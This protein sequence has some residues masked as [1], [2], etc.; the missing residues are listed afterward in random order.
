LPVA[1]TGRV[2]GFS[3][4]A[5]EYL[6]SAFA[7]QKKGETQRSE[8][9]ALGRWARY[10]GETPL[11][12]I[13]G[14]M[15]RAYVEARMGGTFKGKDGV[16]MGA[17][18][19]RTCNLDLTSLRQCLKAAEACGKLR[20]L[21]VI[22][23]LRTVPAVSKRLLTSGEFEA[24]L[25]AVERV[26][27]RNARIVGLYLRF[28]AFT[29]CREKEALRVSWGAVDFERRL[30]LIGETGET[31]NRRGRWIEW[32]AA[33]SSLLSDL[34]GE[35][36]GVSRWLFP[37]PRRGKIDRPARGF[38]DSLKLARAEAGLE[39]VG[40]HHLRHYFASHAVMAGVDFRTVADWLGHRD[41]GVLVGRVYSHLLNEHKRRAAEKVVF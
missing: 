23:N 8:R 26:C 17:A 20:A 27:E 37:S 1:G 10:L 22:R 13:S 18:S 16:A 38:R 25:A 39:W 40:F 19:A 15:V 31:K 3:A 32:N 28:L 12:R 4:W 2:P 11:D 36:A 6:A 5:R 30:I 34:R 24:L 14:P 7:G 33:L 9:D 21:P 29:G 41:G 35:T